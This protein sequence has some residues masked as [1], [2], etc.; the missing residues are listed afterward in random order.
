MVRCGSKQQKTD[1]FFLWHKASVRKPAVQHS[2]M[3]AGLV[4]VCLWFVTTASAL[5]FELTDGSK[6]DGE[7]VMA[8]PDGLQIRMEG[9][10]YEKLD[11][12]KLSQATLTELKKDKKLATF[13]E[14]YIEVP[15]DEKIKK[16]EVTIKEVAR[17]ERPPKGS[18]IGALFSSSIGIVC[19]LLLYG[20]N[21]YAAYEIA[22]VRAY[23]P[24]LVC[25]ISAVAPVI[26]PVIFLCLPTKMGPTQD[27]LA[28]EQRAAI[29]ET[30]AATYGASAEQPASSTQSNSPADSASHTP[31]PAKEKTQSFKRGQFTFNRRFIETKFAGFLGMV[32]KDE[33]KHQM[34]II[35]SARG[36]FAVTRISE[37]GATDMKVDVHAGGASQQVQIPFVEILEMQ[38]KHKDA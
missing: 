16:T 20:A 7:I 37:I 10:K 12:T 8:K 26:G 5:T 36:E 33:E 2:K 18:I 38:I 13:V 27:E 21:L 17:L 28:A 3:L 32:R 34:L 30:Q 29:E 14:P 24:G 1:F 6:V 25:G 31:A 11:W 15:V 23:A 19:M 22:S 35:K 4:F 9:N